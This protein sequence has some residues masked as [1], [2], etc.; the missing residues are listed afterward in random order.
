MIFTQSDADAVLLRCND[1]LAVAARDRMVAEANQRS[2]FGK[3]RTLGRMRAGL[4][5]VI[6]SL[7]AL[8]SIG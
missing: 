4:R 6:A 2:S 3:P 8:A 1:F 5:Q 7:V